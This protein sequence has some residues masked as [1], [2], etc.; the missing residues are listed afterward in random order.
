MRKYKYVLIVYLSGVSVG[1]LCVYHQLDPTSRLH[2]T[3]HATVLQTYLYRSAIS[4]SLL[5]L[6]DSPFRDPPLLPSSFIL[7][8]SLLLSS[9]SFFTPSIFLA[10]LPSLP[11]LRELFLAQTSFE[12]T[13]WKAIIKSVQNEYN[14]TYSNMF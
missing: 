2:V 11:L 10:S 7:L 12:P 13:F 14:Q 9:S 5:F 4:F 6:P 8:T 3:A 1:R